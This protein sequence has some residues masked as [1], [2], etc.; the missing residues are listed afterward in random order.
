MSSAAGTLN[1]LIKEN[2]LLNAACRTAK[3]G[4][5]YV[6][7]VTE[8]AVWSRE[9]FE[10]FE[11]QANA[12]PDLDK[13]RAYIAPESLKLFDVAVKDAMEKQRPY[14]IDL[15]I[16]AE[17]GKRK[18][19]RSLGSPVLENGGVIG[20][21]GTLQDITEQKDAERHA[22]RQELLLH[23]LFKVLPDMFFVIDGDGTIREYQ[24][25]ED[26]ILLLTP[27]SFLGKRI[28]DVLPKESTEKF[29]AAAASLEKNSIA[30]YEY[31]L[32]LQGKTCYYETRMCKVP[33]EDAY[34]AVVRDITE[35]TEAERYKQALTDRLQLHNDLIRQV[36]EMEARI[37]GDILCMS[38]QVS[39][40]I[41]KAAGIERVS[42]WIYE[43]NETVLRCV[44][45]FE[46]DLNRHSHG[47]TIREEDNNKAFWSLKNNVYVE[48]NKTFRDLNLRDT[49]GSEL[50]SAGLKS[51]LLCKIES[52]GANR[53]V[54][55]FSYKSKAHIW[56]NDEIAF[57]CQV[58]NY[59]GMAFITRDR[60]KV[61][62]E[63][64][65]SEY[66]LKRA[67]S[68]A[69]TGHWYLDI[70]KGKMTASDES[71][72]I[73]GIEKGTPLSPDGFLK[74]VYA[75]DAE[76]VKTAWSLALTG[77]PYTINH[78][79]WL[80]NE[81][82]WVEEKAEIEFDENGKA[83]I[84]LGTIQDITEKVYT[85]R[86]LDEY[87]LNLEEMVVSRTKELETAKKAAEAANQAKSSFLSNMS[88]EIRTPIN[89]II[90]YAHLMKRDPLSPRQTD[91][92]V[93][94]AGA[95]RHLLTIIND[96]LDLSKIEASK[97]LLNIDDFETG[98]VIDQACS[99]LEE[100][101][102]AKGL[103]M[104]ADLD[105]IPLMLRGD[106]IRL[107]QILLNLLGNAVKFTEK[108]GVT[109][110]GRIIGQKENLIVVRFEIIDTGIGITAD[111]IHLLFNDF[112]QADESTTRRF[113]G[114]GL[115]LSISRR[116]T[117]IMGGQIGVE[118]EPGKGSMFFVEIP[119]GVSTH[120]PVSAAY[121]NTFTDMRALVIDDLY[122]DR[123][124]I[125]GMLKE[126][127]LRTEEA[128]SGKNGLMALET[129]ERNGDPY[130]LVVLDLKMRDMNGIDIARKL[131]SL[132]LLNQPALLMVT[133][134]G[135]QLSDLNLEGTGITRILDK[136][137]TPSSLFDAIAH[138]FIETPLIEVVREP[139]AFEEQLRLRKGAHVLIV[140][141]NIINQEV[142]CQLLETVGIIANV[143]SNG[144]EAVSM[145]ES[146]RHDLILM[147]I[148][149]PVKDGLQAT[150][151]IRKLPGGLCVPIIAMTA[152]AFEEDRR[153]C[154][155][156]GMNDYVPKPVEPEELF[157]TLIKWIEPKKKNMTDGASDLE[158]I[159]RTEENIDRSGAVDPQ[160]F[161]ALY[162]IEGMD[163]DAGLKTLQGDKSYYLKLLQLFKESQ[164]GKAQ[165]IIAG[166]EKM[167][168]DTVKMIV[169][170][171][172]GVSGNLGAS[173]IYD[174]TAEIEKMGRENIASKQLKK[175]LE[176]LSAEL[177]EL[178]MKLQTALSQGE[179]AEKSKAESGMDASEFECL[180]NA[181]DK[182]LKKN[183]TA[184]SEI[185]EKSKEALYRTM[186]DTA[187]E[188]DIDIQKFDFAEALEAL[189]KWRS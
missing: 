29:P 127:G 124:L 98:R 122:N 52:G 110:K 142:M 116:L 134:Y 169:H 148:Q 138:L 175:R 81:I 123:E 93:K 167:D 117:E 2:I 172:K 9:T 168:Y 91:Q 156:A 46:A 82:R 75:D 146:V 166:L 109:I 14:S 63:L 158:D 35:E 115:G 90:G 155:E 10:I 61:V 11:L 133:A 188:I 92:I 106:G 69:K 105:H 120:Q 24:S 49:D 7:L 41:A 32:Q 70:A 21:E 97:L 180:L 6:N 143:V 72:R 74:L 119:F 86:Q 103:Y 42:I 164:E 139:K 16:T 77:T 12:A 128:D 44:D 145:V 151:E 15:E 25:K 17:T 185:F 31:E 99:I 149:M 85:N 160:I 153:N 43:E 45:S 76:H 136:P 163:I 125:C 121:V 1:D 30:S 20:L 22:N 179:C 55:C 50:I 78:R 19:I 100:D 177:S 66:F 186:G 27:E 56:G 152:N 64:R 173:R 183:D 36:S 174:L 113:G 26:N 28:Y 140:E 38:K 181:L 37:D 3:V 102:A 23:S 8:T 62:E 60:L 126:L 144:Q 176:K 165:E 184:V 178:M 118:S 87:R 84:G 130:K 65:K 141:D 34:I 114:T 111:Q 132:G 161:E 89:A 95:A 162:K 94:L 129:A 131:P 154:I 54:I 33:G 73:F 189:R 79:I 182:L 53:G 96:I 80:N 83:L 4:G 171:L 135:A 51:L 67:Q 112:E 187:R 47:R 57:S 159:G 107:G 13:T 48:A 58:A 101:A 104:R 88:H 147:D 39:E 71:Y 137:L 170:A 5:W 108:G 18:W 157:R 59:F 150:R 40:L 68:V